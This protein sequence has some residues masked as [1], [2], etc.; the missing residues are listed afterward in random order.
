MPRLSST[1]PELF[2]LSHSKCSLSPTESCNELQYCF[3]GFSA[4]TALSSCY[5]ERFVERGRDGKVL[6][7]VPCSSCPALGQAIQASRTCVLFKLWTA[8]HITSVEIELFKNQHA[9]FQ[10]RD[11]KTSLMG[12]ARLFSGM[13]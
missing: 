6:R 13:G 9:A 3:G 12:G 5:S 10:N 4:G 7:S 8:C 2:L 1:H 11:C